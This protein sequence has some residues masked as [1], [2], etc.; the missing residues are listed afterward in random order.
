MSAKGLN[1]YRNRH[2]SSP[3]AG[4]VIV[5]NTGVSRSDNRHEEAQLLLPG[6]DPNW[7][8]WDSN[9]VRPMTFEEAQRVLVIPQE[10]Q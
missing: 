10:A 8:V 1:R 3:S 7:M 2:P 5:G 6:F 4:T 9:G